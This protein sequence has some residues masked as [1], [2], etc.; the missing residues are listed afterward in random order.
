MELRKLCCHAFML[1][2]VEPDV[3]PADAEEGL[4]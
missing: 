2:G 3:E 1:E 4:R